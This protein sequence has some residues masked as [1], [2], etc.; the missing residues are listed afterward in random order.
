MDAASGLTVRVQSNTVSVFV[1]P[2][3]VCTLTPGQTVVRVP[4]SNYVLPHVLGNA[5]NTPETCELDLQLLAGNT[6]TPVG[7]QVVEDLNGNG[8]VDPGEPV[9]VNGFGGSPSPA[10]GVTLNPGASVNLLVVG[11]VP[12]ASPGQSA[13]MQLDATSAVQRQ[14][15]SAQDTVVVISGPAL[16]VTKSATPSNPVQGGTVTYTLSESNI[17]NSPALG[18]GVQVDGASVNLVVLRDGIPANTTFQNLGVAGTAQQLFHLLGQPLNTYVSVP[19]TGATVDAIGWGLPSLAAGASLTGQFTVSVGANAAGM[20]DNVGYVDYMSTG[21]ITVPSNPVSLPLPSLPA[22]IGFYPDGGYSHPISQSGLGPPLF[23]QVNAAVCN[24]NGSQVES[25]PIRL[26][27]ALGNDVETFMGV[28]TGPNTGIFRIQPDV[29][30]ADATT[31]PVVTGDGILE[32]FPNDRVTATLL[33]C[34]GAGPISASIL[35]DP[36]GVVYD[37]NSNQPLAGATVTLIDVTGGG[38][39]GHPGGPA[40]VFQADGTTPAS[41]VV[42]TGGDG[43]FVFPLVKPSTYAFQVAPPLGYRFPSQLPPALQPLGRNVVDP[44]SYGGNFTLTGDG[45]I[46][47]DIPLDPHAT[48]GLIV[49]KTASKTAVEVG[50]FLDYAITVSDQSGLNLKDVILTDW[51]PPGFEYVRGSARIGGQVV[52]DPTRANGALQFALGMVSN[53][54]QVV[55][56]YRVAVTPSA[57]SGNGINSARA[58]S[59]DLLSNLA[60]VRVQLLGGVFD[61]HAVLIGKVY[62]DCNANRVQDPGEP[63]IPGVRIWLADGTYAVTDGD[64]KYSLYGLTPRTTVAAVDKITLPPGTTLEVLDHRNA[65]DPSSQFVDL[66]NG[67]LH[68]TDFAIRECG[69]DVTAAIKERRLALVRPDEI[70]QRAQNLLSTNSSAALN[71]DARSLPA[72]GTLGPNGV[73]PDGTSVP[74]RGTPLG[75]VGDM[76]GSLIQAWPTSRPV[77]P[78]Q[79][80]TPTTVASAPIETAPIGSSPQAAP[81]VAAPVPLPDLLPGLDANAAFIEPVDQE[82]LATAQ[83]RVRVKGPAGA[84]LRLRVNGKDIDTSY[85]GTRTTLPSSGVVAWEYI[86]INLKPGENTLEL[87]AVDGFG[88]ERGKSVVHVIAP[89]NLAKLR[90]VVPDKAVADATTPIRVKVEALDAAGVPVTSRVPVTLQTDQGIWQVEDLNK[91][92][93]GTQTFIEGGSAEFA[94]LPPANPAN[95]TLHVQSGSIQSDQ[96]LTFT[97]FLRPMMAVGLVEGV[98][99]LRRLDPRSIQTTDGT[100]GFERAI[101]GFSHDFDHGKADVSGRTQVFLKGKVLGSTLLTLG[102]DSDKPS[103]TQLFRDIQP[104]RFYPIYGDSSVKGFDAQSTGK[105]YVRLDHG[106]SYVLLGDYSTQT[107]NP[108]RQITQYTRALYG[109]RAHGVMN[110]LTTDV[111]ASHTASTQ[112]VV[113]IPGNG[114]SGPYQLDP[115]GVIN[116]QQVD[117]IVRDRT[118][119]N[120]IV[121]DKPLTPFVDYTI[122]PITGLLLFSAPVPTVDANLNPVFIRVN[123]EVDNG[124]P[125]HWVGGLAAEWQVAK[126]FAFGV[127]GVRDEDPAKRLDLY[128]FDFTLRFGANSTLVGEFAHSNTPDH[129]SGNAERLEWRGQAERLQGRIW[130]IHSD[131]AFQNPSAMQS[132]GQGQYGVQLG[133][134]LTDQ[135]R[136]VVEGLRTVSPSINGSQ[137]GVSA[138][139]QHNFAHDVRLSVG[140][141]HAQGQAQTTI[142]SSNGSLPPTTAVDF[143]SGFVRVDAPVPGLPKANVFAQY[144]RAFD[145]DAQVS[146]LGGTYSL[147]NLGK[148]YFRHDSSN[149]LSGAFGLNPAVNQYTTVFGLQTTLADKTELFNEYRIGQGID[150]RAAED[151]IGLRHLWQLA[152]GLAMSG[153]AEKIKPVSG[154]VG[155][156]SQ[157]LTAAISDTRSDIWK[158][159]ARLEWRESLQTQSWLATAATAYKLSPDWTVLARGYYNDV[160]NRGGNTGAQHQGEF[161]GGFAYRPADNDLWNALG[162]VGY[163]RNQDTTLPTGQQID[164][165]AWIFLTQVEMQPSQPWDITTRLATKFAR[166]DS[167][168]IRSSGWTTLVGGRV[169]RDIGERWDAGLQ[170]YTSW[171]FGSRHRAAGVELGYLLR[172]NFW[173]SIGYNVV[174]FNDPDLAGGAYTQDGFYLRFRFKFGSDLFESVGDMK[175]ARSQANAAEN[176]WNS[177]GNDAHGP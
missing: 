85:V 72:S 4:G 40:S 162:M 41:N 64:G 142:P 54:G 132:A 140:V 66:K 97:P 62:A 75:A 33:G 84:N 26:N 25:Y 86:G 89:G 98:L 135:D 125:R 6:F 166:D 70:A 171:G 63:G 87:S 169:T 128:G 159:S 133:Y 80:T 27:T 121:S 90:I 18:T 107:D 83:T 173:L 114:T 93:P 176:V 24:L 124:G 172:R 78:G 39:G 101:E 5:G 46:Q 131:A 76:G 150:G 143:T 38:N 163:K 44:G 42:V 167:N 161:Q 74:L 47:I 28:E 34:A 73:V 51:L 60:T 126:A 96:K 92:E 138:S 155:D 67:E 79:Q 154:K 91:D 103:D 100:E 99:D 21:T 14:H 116:S 174:G 145:K 160:Q 119:T 137:A 68:K 120:V 147:G 1:Q 108:A 37:S 156:E 29:P 15:V 82:T 113:E 144:E 10:T 31:H 122:E 58:Q 104:N 149:S 158:S 52:P 36:R 43:V 168:G 3:E 16:T 13:S 152:P 81:V 109:L 165:Q 170:A 146:S 45:P 105:L 77:F 151:A 153:T 19:P 50:D 59:G 112:T 95:A 139:L 61:N 117:L 30:T 148:L 20:I 127:S 9:L 157:A 17:G 177:P 65:L 8:V 175:A 57:L 35:I 129:G 94:L 48:S 106:T 69:A 102:Y 56:T 49:Q 22:T 136:I 71:L 88:I 141:R 111:F 53:G 55:V 11:A 134:K 32:V 123:Y 2:I 110:G 12:A 118:Q 115:R 7:A 164:E 23:V 130:G